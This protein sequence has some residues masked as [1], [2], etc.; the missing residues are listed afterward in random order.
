[1]NVR[2]A[3]VVGALALAVPAVAQD[4][5]PRETVSAVVGGKKVA[6]EYGRPS[7]KGRD[8][9]AMLKQLPADKVWR[10][11]SE[12][13]TT[14][15]TEGAV[16]V[17]GKKLPAGKYSV[18]VVVADDGTR[19][20][21][22]NTDG[23]MP[24]GELWAGAPAELKTAPWPQMGPKGYAAVADKEVARVKMAKAE[25]ATPTDMFTVKMTDKVLTMAWGNESWSTT[26]APAS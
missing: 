18:Y 24:L 8:L 16:M 7:L 5:A 19:S 1:M 22:L 26:L 2:M 25:L 9:G 12:Q 6:V 21:L 10:A 23:G 4:A 15:T 14:L 13:V 20:L 11:G 3:F 17:G